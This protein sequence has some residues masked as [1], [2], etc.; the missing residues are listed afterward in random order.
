MQAFTEQWLSG[1]LR[2][3]QAYQG[4][5]TLPMKAMMVIPYC[6]SSLSASTYHQA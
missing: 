3:A 4:E 2:P 6:L 5:K 1:S